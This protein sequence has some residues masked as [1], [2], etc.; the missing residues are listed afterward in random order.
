MRNNSISRILA[1]S[2]MLVMLLASCSKDQALLER[3]AA[4]QKTLAGSVIV[5]NA[6]DTRVDPVPGTGAIALVVDPAEANPML[7]V[8]NNTWKMVTTNLIPAADRRLGYFKMENIPAGT[9]NVLVETQK[10]G[11]RNVQ[12]VGVVVTVGGLL[13][14]GTVSLW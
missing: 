3:N 5:T 1:T 8:Y 10:Q 9:Y 6:N 11:F 13:N 12:I 7:T 14:L 4:T 2:C